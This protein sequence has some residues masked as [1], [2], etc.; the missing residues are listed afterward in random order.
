MKAIILAAG[1][2]TRLYPLTIDKPKA[3]L[4][5]KGKLLLNHILEKIPPSIEEIFIVTNDKFYI[6][7]AWWLQQQNKE[8]KRR[9]DIINDGTISNETRLGGIGDLNLVI[10]EKN[11]S[12]DILVISSDNFFTFSLEDFINF[13]NKVKKTT[14]GI[15]EISDKEKLK[16]YGI[17]EV[18]ESKVVGFEEKPSE[19]K[20]NLASIG[21]YLFSKEDVE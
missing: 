6:Q 1:Y 8:M 15:F 7:F 4:E 10:Q 19:P 16:K 17:I 3:L 5:I 21:I 9:V 13:F 2:G 20:S 18:N 12:D 14:I 11:I